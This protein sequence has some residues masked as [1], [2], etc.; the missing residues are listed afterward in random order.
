M[1]NI[2]IGLL[3]LCGLLTTA[4]ATTPQNTVTNTQSSH[5]P[6]NIIFLIGDGMGVEHTTAYRYYT[7]DLTT[8]AVET[9]IFDQLL[10]GMAS[11]YPDDDTVVT[12]SAASATALSSGVKS[13]NGAIGVDA[14]KEPLATVL[15]KA[16]QLGKQTAIVVTSQINHATP[17]AFI[18]HNESR[19]NYDQIADNYL[20]NLINDKPIVDLMFGGGTKYFIRDDRNL[21]KEFEDYGYQYTDDLQQLDNITA[22]PALG[23]FAPVGLPFAIDSAQPHRLEPMAQKAL[24]LLSQHND[25]G[26]FMMIEGSQIDW[27]SHANDVA[28]AMGELDDFAATIKAAR[29]FAQQQGDTLVVVTADHSTG[30]LSIGG[31]GQYLWKRDLVHQIH[32]SIETLSK[33]MIK[34][35]DVV[36][37]WNKYI[38]F[39]LT[40]EEKQKLLNASK[41]KDK[42]LRDALVEVISHRTITGWTSRGHTAGD[43]QIFAYGVGAE[44]FAG[45]L[46]NTDIAKA[47]FSF[48]K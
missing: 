40:T 42:M 41:Q 34:T 37:T 20:S 24:S 39:A 33:E 8:E 5:V 44:K 45:H 6:K 12:D 22:L 28:C 31:Y 27:C 46:D 38:D 17:A 13:Y 16:K 7:D 32:A 1:K 11:T 29:D 19:Q 25:N 47:I 48:L 2:S 36:A 4:C 10:V 30:G 35:N 23:L 14:H 21:V 43:V 15:E 3:L 18:A 26:F 9:T